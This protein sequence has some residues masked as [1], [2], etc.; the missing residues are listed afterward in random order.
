MKF[1]QAFAAIALIGFV[2]MFAVIAASYGHVWVLLVVLFGSV[3][4]FG[5][6][7]C[8]AH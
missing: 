3:F 4:A 6:I 8:A 2:N 1:F 5:K 7:G